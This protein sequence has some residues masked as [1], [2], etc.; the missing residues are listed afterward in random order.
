MFQ[1]S[2]LDSAVFYEAQVSASPYGALIN[3]IDYTPFPTYYAFTAFNR[4]YTLGTQVAARTDSDTLYAAAAANETGGCIVMVNPTKDP[5]PL[6]LRTNAAITRCLITANGQCEQ[7]TALPDTLPPFSI[8][9][10]E[11]T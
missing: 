2:A 11:T 4:L 1:D 8:V 9:T 6:T 7:E 3:P 5:L 10:V